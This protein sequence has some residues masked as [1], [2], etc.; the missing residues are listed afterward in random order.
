MSDERSDAPYA[1]DRGDD[2]GPTEAALVDA[3]GLTPEEVAALDDIVDPSALDVPADRD[4]A[5][6]ATAASPDAAGET[7]SDVAAGG[8]ADPL[9]EPI[10]DPEDLSSAV[11]PPEEI[12]T[13]PLPDIG[14]SDGTVAW[15]LLLAEAAATLAEAGIETAEGDARRIIEEAT[16]LDGAELVV[17]LDEPATVGGVA[18][19]DRMVERRLAG[20]PLQYV[21]GRWGF[22]T[23]DLMVDARVL[24]PRPETEGVV[25]HV[26]AELD[27]VRATHAPSPGV[28]VDLGCG[29]G[30]IGLSVAQER[31]GTEVHA[32]DRAPGAVA[33]TRANLT[34]L[35]IAGATVY[36]HQ[37]SWFAPLPEEL[38]GR[39]SVVASNPPYVAADDELP[40]AVADWEPAEAL[41]PGPTGLEAVEVILVEAPRWLV[42]GGSVVLEI[43]ETQGDAVRAL[44]E[45]AG[46]VDVE[47]R[48]DL[49]GRDRALVARWPGV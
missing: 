5:V 34:G 21:L 2:G 17:H 1:V 25:D 38:V 41:V 11:P 46:F 3:S 35:G 27:R 49:A 29:S 30:A 19:L 24:I 7:D 28:V 32:V 18:A 43:G 22:R 20:E 23:L 33:V 42:D 31:S 40:A 36:V 37:G 8:S 26:L 12:S 45:A 14:L 6:P 39:V 16:G 13:V 4:G 47:V 9:A 10:P 44:A 15:R 48:P